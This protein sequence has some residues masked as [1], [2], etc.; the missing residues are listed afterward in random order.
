MRFHALPVALIGLPLLCG[1][2]SLGQ[3]SLSADPI[4]SQVVDD[5]TGV[6]IEGAVVV[7]HWELHG[8]SIGGDSLPCGSANV[9]E[10]VTDKDGRFHL[11]GW[12]P[13]RVGC[14]GEMQIG[15]PLIYIFKSGYGYGY[16]SNGYGVQMVTVTHSDFDGRQMSLKRFP[17]MNLR[18]QGI[19]SYQFDFGLLNGA[20]GNFTVNMP[21]ECNWKKMPHMIVAIDSQAKEF[22]RALGYPFGTMNARLI[23][24]D[25]WILKV[26]PQC[27]SPK[28]FIESLV[29]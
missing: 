4:S 27:G 15:N 8:G 16:F 26:A 7:A 1:C 21:D 29:K 13:T 17:D 24:N 18:K 6:P 5:D 2:S 20:L 3:T 10:A 14:A 28:A 11:P 22:T 9:E 23:S 25:Q 19:G 12:G